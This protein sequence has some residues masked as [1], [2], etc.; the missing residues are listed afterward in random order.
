M[1]FEWLISLSN[2]DKDIP[3]HVRCATPVELLFLNRRDCSDG[4]GDQ[5][6]VQDLDYFNLA[7]AGFQVVAIARLINILL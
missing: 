1:L 7:G 6:C 3:L 4:T 2:H 5:G